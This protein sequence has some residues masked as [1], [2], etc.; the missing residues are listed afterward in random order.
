MKRVVLALSLIVLLSMIGI[1]IAAE[2]PHIDMSVIGSSTQS[3][4]TL[5]QAE[6]GMYYWVVDLSITNNGYQ[7]F[8]IDPSYFIAYLGNAK[9]SPNNATKF[10][11]SL[12]RVPLAVS[13]LA[14]GE[15]ATGSLVFYMPYDV[16]SPH[17]IDYNG[18]GNYNIR[19]KGQGA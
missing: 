2:A 6:V 5:K 14:N 4:G 3:V 11:S 19:W 17:S 1:S 10:L 13:Q 9:Y 16:N 7:G 15:T 18:P 12:N 8:N